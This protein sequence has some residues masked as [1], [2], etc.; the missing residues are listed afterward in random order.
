[1]IKKNMSLLVICLLVIFGFGGC[2]SKNEPIIDSN[3]KNI[4]ITDM[5]GRNVSL[6]NVAKRVV[7]IGPGVLDFIV[8]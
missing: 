4:S 2:N 5:I 1:M 6:N 7:A 3:S 8:M